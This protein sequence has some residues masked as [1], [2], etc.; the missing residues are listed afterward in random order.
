VLAE[1]YPPAAM[2]MAPATRHARPATRIAL[3]SD[4]AVATPTPKLAVDTSRHWHPVP[5]AATSR[6][7]G[8]SGLPNG[9]SGSPRTL[10]VEVDRSHHAGGIAVLNQPGAM[11]S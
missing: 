3:W 2:D 6:C 7:D 9:L 4:P 10:R 8:P 11:Q 5:R 1:T